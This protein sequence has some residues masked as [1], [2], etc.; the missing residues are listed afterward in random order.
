LSKSFENYN[1]LR[2]ENNGAVVIPKSSKPL[3]LISCFSFSMLIER[4]P[5]YINDSDIYSVIFDSD[6]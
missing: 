6:V 2:G 3:G 1:Y 4:S 5:S